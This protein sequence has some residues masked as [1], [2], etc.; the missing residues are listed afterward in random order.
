MMQNELL[1]PALYCRYYMASRV[2]TRTCLLDKWTNHVPVCERQSF[3]CCARLRRVACWQ[4][5]HPFA[6]S[7]LLPAFKCDLPPADGEVV[8]KGLPDNEQDV[9][10]DRFLRFS[11]EAP[12]KVLNGSSMLICGKD[13]KWDHP[14]PTCEGGNQERHLGEETKTG[15]LFLRL[16]P[17]FQTSPVLLRRCTLPSVSPEPRKQTGRWRSDT[18]YSLSAA[19]ASP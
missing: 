10:P 18:N 19:M 17:V 15:W 9:L 11:C 13:G 5:S 8:I 6:H 4:K 16:F 1:Q 7:C 12:G 3:Y 2:D 14:F